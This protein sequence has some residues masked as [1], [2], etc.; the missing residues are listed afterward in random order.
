MGACERNIGHTHNHCEVNDRHSDQ[1]AHEWEWDKC[2]VNMW[3]R[4]VMFGQLKSRAKHRNPVLLIMSCASLHP[5]QIEEDDT[6]D[7]SAWTLNFESSVLNPTTRHDKKQMIPHRC[8]ENNLSMSEDE[9]GRDHRWPVHPDK[10]RTFT[11]PEVTNMCRSHDPRGPI[12][13]ATQRT[14]RIVR[15][16]VSDEN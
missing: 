11:I 8:H 4:A 3:M 5:T 12:N 14:D 9:V 7:T 2:L 10:A 13:F 16:N 6:R 15:N 1:H